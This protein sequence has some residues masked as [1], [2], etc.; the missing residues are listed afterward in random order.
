MDID[1]NVECLRQLVI[2]G[3]LSA[4]K[5]QS[6]ED[7]KN[8]I[9]KYGSSLLHYAAGCGHEDTC[10]FL[11]QFFDDVNNVK[12]H[13]N[14]RT[15][16]H[17]AARNGHTDICKVLVLECG[18]QVDALAKGGVTPLE[19]S[20]WQCQLPTAK[21]LVEELDANPHHPNS[22]G[23]TTAHWLGKCPI[24]NNDGGGTTERLQQACDWLFK[25][26][27]VDYNAPNHH[28]QTPL[29]KAAYAGNFAVAEYL[30][31]KIGVI[32]SIRDNNGNTAADC[33][34]RDQNYELAKWLR[35]HAS[36]EVHRA[37]ES[38]ELQRVEHSTVPPRPER[39]RAAYL[40][41]AKLHHTDVSGASSIR[42]WDTIRD[43]HQ[44][45]Q[46]YWRDDP[47]LFDCQIRILSRNSK[48]LEH[49]RLC[50]HS[51]WHDENNHLQENDAIL[52]EF[53]SRLVR[54]LSSNSFAETGLCIAQL[55]REYEKSFHAK[56]P[57]PRAHGCRKLIHLL[58]T[59]CS[60]I[61]VEVA[62]CKKQAV[63]RIVTL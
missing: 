54:L 28:G 61:K 4:L 13:N 19:L 24:Y 21:Y 55:P 9:D 45:L 30:V 53:E 7:L 14:Q 56:V 40:Q 20:I 31:V 44:L 15:P 35:R 26:C 1:H 48:L 12:S 57:L 38:L 18:A 8:N 36:A 37:I 3:D 11:M 58:Q 32:D 52:A 22:W 39:I 2:D 27:G 6:Q 47:E 51:S 16:L 10:R 62:D 63:L 50:W 25:D 33:G 5:K 23:C 60:N 43:A 46:S 49:K 42:H 41:L 59:K 34:E 29:H 17:W